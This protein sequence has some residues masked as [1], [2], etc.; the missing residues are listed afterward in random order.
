MLAIAAGLNAL[1]H[2]GDGITRYTAF[3]IGGII[4]A[5][6]FIAKTPAEKNW[7]WKERRGDPPDWD[8]LSGGR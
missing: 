4:L 6:V 8:Q 2:I 5:L 7:T 1:D 3:N